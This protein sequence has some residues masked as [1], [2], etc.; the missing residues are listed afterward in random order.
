M[1]LSRS[2]GKTR[3]SLRKTELLFDAPHFSDVVSE[4]GGGVLSKHDDDLL[5][6]KHGEL[7]SPNP[8]LCHLVGDRPQVI[9]D[10][11]FVIGFL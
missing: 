7:Y 8:F 4:L 6:L 11:G 2:L 1:G 9:I 10:T 3:K 5:I